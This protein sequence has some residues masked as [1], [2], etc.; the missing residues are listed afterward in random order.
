MKKSKEL[1][2]K[3]TPHLF[4]IYCG[5][6]GVSFEEKQIFL[7][8]LDDINKAKFQIESK[9]RYISEATGARVCCIYDC[10]RVAIETQIA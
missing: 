5:G 1:K 6:H 9:F 3:D 8:N 7:L 2:A 10:C 4:I